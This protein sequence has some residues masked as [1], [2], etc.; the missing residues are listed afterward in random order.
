MAL[1]EK[2]VPYEFLARWDQSG[3]FSGAHVQF[4]TVITDDVTGE[5][6]LQ[7]PGKV[8]TVDVGAGQGFPVADI[9]D[10]LHVD[11]IARADAAMAAQASADKA[12][13][14]A[15]AKETAMQTALDSALAT[16]NAA[17]ESNTPA[18]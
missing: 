2:Q 16:L 13:A 8:M 14:D 7:T 4:A 18:V 10:Q 9:L 17:K 6:K 12:A 5:V 11:S 15:V 1:V 3:K